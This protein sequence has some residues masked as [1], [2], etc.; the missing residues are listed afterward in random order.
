MAEPSPAPRPPRRLGMT[1]AICLLTV[2]GM[3][4][5]TAA[6]VP[7]YRIFCAATGYGGTPQRVQEASKHVLDREVTILFDSNVAPGLGWRF[8]AE[9]PSIRL[10][11]GEVGQVSFRAENLSGLPTSGTASFN[12]LPEQVG[13]YF[14]KIACFCFNR[15]DLAPGE[16]AEMPVVF[17]VDPRIADDPTLDYVDTITLSYSFFPATPPPAVSAAA[18]GPKGKPL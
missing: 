5:L 12:V 17:Y 8:R 11:I 4:G 3:T 14:N 7:L 10:K 13:A 2:A 18:D 6:A 15:Q 1:A 9:Q 16:T